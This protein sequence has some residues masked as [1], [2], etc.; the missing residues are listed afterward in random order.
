[1]LK[2]SLW[3]ATIA[4]VVGA[5]LLLTPAIG[6]AQNR[7]GSSWGRS[8]GGSWNRGGGGYGNYGRGGWNQGYGYGGYSGIGIGIYP[9]FYGRGAYGY[10]GDNGGYYG[11][12]GY[13]PESYGVPQSGYQSFYPPN[14]GSNQGY[15]EPPQAPASD[16]SAA[17][18]MV[19][20][21]DANAEVWFQDHQT[22]QRGTVRVYESSGLNPNQ[23][24]TF[25][26][27]ARWT[28]NGR[29]VDQSRDVQVR[30]GQHVT[31]NFSV[32]ANDSVPVAPA[33]QIPRT[34][35]TVP[36]APAVQI[37]RNVQDAPDAPAPQLPRNI[38]ND[39]DAPTAQPP[40]NIQPSR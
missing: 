10:Y 9:G 40:R 36:V 11:A 29:A 24:Y 22:Q 8:G 23:S 7:G 3:A 18:F 37:R 32:P 14:A 28:Q 19:R 25:H 38:Q 31:V 2:N 15:A 1:M 6:E 16:P 30:A 12:Q 39:S 5:G 34:I 26:V 20:V 13:A 35:Q 21:P 4:V 27:R 33:V 17:G